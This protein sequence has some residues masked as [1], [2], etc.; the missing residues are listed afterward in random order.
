MKQITA[1]TA[2][3]FGAFTLGATAPIVMG[4][5]RLPLGTVGC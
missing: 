5:D 4:P 2:T 3:A 1:N